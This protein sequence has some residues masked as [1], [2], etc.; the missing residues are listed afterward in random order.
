M[1]TIQKHLSATL[2]PLYSIKEE[3]VNSILHGIGTAAAIAGLVLLYLKT[4]GVL[5]GDRAGN[6]E[7]A[8]SII[9]AATMTGMFLISTLYHAIQYRSAKDILRR[10]D[11]SIIFVFIAGTYTPIC[12]IG[13][14]GVW[15]WS[16]FFVQWSLALLGIILKVLCFKPLK[17][18]QVAIYI[19]A[20]WII[21]VGFVPLL[22][23]VPLLSIILLF[24]GGIV[25]TLGTI[26]Y[27]RK[28][29]RFTHAIWHVFVMLGAVFHWFSVWF[30]Y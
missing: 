23:S 12:L 9:F 22:R 11:H 25:Y 8:A 30:L 16:L 3:I 15:G 24:T 13:I 26:W 27:R 19:I 14:G 4:G 21:V 7:I 1:D 2:L 28:N 20:G 29:I 18:V 17:K 6:L 5:S 10:L